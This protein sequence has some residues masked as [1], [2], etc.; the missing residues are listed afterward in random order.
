MPRRS[1]RAFAGARRGDAMGRSAFFVFGMCWRRVTLA[2]VATV[3]MSVPVVARPQ[4]QTGTTGQAPSDTSAD[5]LTRR[6]DELE[7]TTREQ[8]EALRKEL[9]ERKAELAREREQRAELERRRRARRD[10]GARGGARRD[11]PGN[12]D[13]GCADLGRLAERPL[14]DRRGSEDG[15]LG[16]A[17][18]GAAG[19]Q[20]HRRK[21]LQRRRVQ[22]ARRGVAPDELSVQFDAGRRSG[23]EGA[24]ARSH[25]SRR[26][27]QCRWWELRALAGFT[28]MLVAVQGPTTLGGRTAGYLEFDFAQ[29]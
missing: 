28:R 17:L 27:R 14:P 12:P 11:R 2:V 20:G 21:R 9:E 16:S 10:A 29:I 23:L 1:V 18:G 5:A 26:G 19:R 7:R 3:V 15:E 13:D 24:G 4:S 8:I 25:D 22:S 6:I